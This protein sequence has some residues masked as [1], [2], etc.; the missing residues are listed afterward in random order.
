MISTDAHAAAVA[1]ATP[2]KFHAPLTIAALKRGC[3][4]F[5]EKPMAMTLAEARACLLAQTP[6]VVV[7]DIMFYQHC[8]GLLVKV[9]GNPILYVYPP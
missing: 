5:C 4:V 6:D 3:H 2:N 9:N 7:L 1:V 8:R